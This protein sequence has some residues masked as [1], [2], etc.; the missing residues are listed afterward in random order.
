MRILLD[1]NAPSGLRRMLAGHDMRTAPEMGWA[2]YSNGQLLDEAEKAGF[3]A[4]ITGDRSLPYQQNLAG[5][6]IAV[7]IFSTN[8]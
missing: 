7:I 2:H 1:E 5:R 3:E 4:L 6:N 8:A